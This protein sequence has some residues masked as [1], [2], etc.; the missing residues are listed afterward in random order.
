MAPVSV[1]RTGFDPRPRLRTDPPAIEGVR[2]AACVHPSLEPVTRCPVCG[3]EV[4]PTTFASTGTVFSGTVLR[5]PVGDRTPPISLAYVDLDDGPRVL[6]H[7]NDPEQALRPGQR[8]VLVGRT[9]EGDPCFAG[10]ET[11]RSGA[12]P[13]S[14]EDA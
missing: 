7:G 4:A 2:C 13:V 1:E 10:E 9:A 8:A 5:I 11:E 6:G 14:E 12:R 3:G